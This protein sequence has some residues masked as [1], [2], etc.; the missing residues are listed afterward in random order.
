L[1]CETD[2]LTI[3]KTDICV[4]E[5]P[6]DYYQ[7]E[8]L[9]R[10]CSIMPNCISCNSNQVCDACPV[11]HYLM[12]P[13]KNSCVK[14]DGADES[15]IGINCFKNT[16]VNFVRFDSVKENVL[17]EVV[18]PVLGRFIYVMAFDDEN[19]PNTEAALIEERLLKPS[20]EQDMWTVY[21]SVKIDQPNEKFS[22]TVSPIRVNTKYRLVGYCTDDVQQKISEKALVAKASSVDNGLSDWIIN[23]NTTQRISSFQKLKVICAFYNLTEGYI[24]QELILSDEGQ[25]CPSD[26]VNKDNS[27][28]IN[29]AP[30]DENA[31]QYPNYIFVE[32]ETLCCKND[33]SL[34]Q[35]ILA[36][37]DFLTL[38]SEKSGVNLVATDGPKFFPAKTRVK[39]RLPVL[40]N[41][42]T[43]VSNTSIVLHLRTEANPAIVYAGVTAT[44]KGGSVQPSPQKF[45]T[46]VDASEP[47]SLIKI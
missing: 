34:I 46:R 4:K 19:Q 6:V 24:R 32:K 2:Y 15:I 14:C 18:C 30:K 36:K 7:F 5:C 47:P 13:G 39:P 21:G 16:A 31:T 38:L 41:V 20:V 17:Y 1:E 25:L 3:E 40:Y 22:F 33:L 11:A 37:P 29:A 35:Q 43:N 27:N 9:C 44:P 10:S 12:L 42:M 8:K 23:F 45:M 26:W 28:G